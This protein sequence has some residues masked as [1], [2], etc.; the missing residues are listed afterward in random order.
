MKY[1]NHHLHFGFA[2]NLFD[3]SCHMLCKIYATKDLESWFEYQTFFS[4]ST[5]RCN[6]TW[7]QITFGTLWKQCHTHTDLVTMKAGVALE[8]LETCQKCWNYRLEILGIQ[9]IEILG[10]W[11]SLTISPIWQDSPAWPSS[12]PRK[13]WNG[14]FNNALFKCDII[15]NHQWVVFN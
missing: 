3:L 15:I 6:I 14:I 8:R 1:W 12:S 10:P 5:R 9:P 13:I 2:T 4:Q 7:Y 11:K